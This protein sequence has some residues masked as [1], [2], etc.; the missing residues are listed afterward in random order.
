MNHIKLFLSQPLLILLL[1][2]CTVNKGTC[3]FISQPVTKSFTTIQLF[4]NLVDFWHCWLNP[5]ANSIE[6]H[7]NSQRC[8]CG[9]RCSN[10]ATC[11][12]T[13]FSFIY[14]CS[15][16][17]FPIFILLGK[18]IFQYLVNAVWC[19]ILIVYRSLIHA[20]EFVSM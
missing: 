18:H 17:C 16:N 19:I 5:P 13:I 4:L 1:L 3:I 2:C 14:N 12:W 7:K 11:T 10:K 15:Y 8:F 6:Q 20:V 9:N